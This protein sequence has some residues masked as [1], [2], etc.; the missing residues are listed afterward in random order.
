LIRPVQHRLALSDRTQHCDQHGVEA[1]GTF[2]VLF[3]QDV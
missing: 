1:I 2:N 3:R